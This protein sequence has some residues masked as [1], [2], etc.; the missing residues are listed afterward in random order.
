ML[1]AAS[2]S[3]SISSDSSDEQESTKNS[4]EQNDQTV[5][6]DA[7]DAQEA[8]EQWQ[9]FT[10]CILDVQIPVRESLNPLRIWIG[11]WVRT[12]ELDQWAIIAIGPKGACV[13]ASALSYHLKRDVKE[14][15]SKLRMPV[16]LR[17]SLD[18]PFH[19][20]LIVQ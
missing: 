7:V 5:A 9:A 14:R 1:G 19:T 15:E 8:Q 17:G 10:E 3:I 4:S 11:D 16:T 12:D 13:D 6:L 2:T 18:S 20:S